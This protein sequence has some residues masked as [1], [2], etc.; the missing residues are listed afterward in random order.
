M[1]KDKLLTLSIVIPVYN[2]ENHLKDCLDA[3]AKQTIKP[4]EVIVVN[5]NSTDNSVKIANSYKF[6][7]VLHEQRQHQVFAQTT[8]FNA[9]KGDILGRIDGDSV[10][11]TNWTERVLSEFN[12]SKLAAV[13]TMAEPYDIPLKRIGMVIFE[14]YQVKLMHFFTSKV[15]LWGSSM[16]MR[17]KFWPYVYEK[18]PISDN[19]WEDHEMS[20]W[21]AELGEV[22]LL[23]DLKIGCS[24]RT[25]H[26]PFFTQLFY[27]FRAIRVFSMHNSKLKT[28]AFFF[29]WY[30]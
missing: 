19:I 6:V 26:K 14:F 18:M 9:A 24:F 22:K 1:L 29:A 30:S 23:K 10:L 15:M 17:A 11:P 16:A 21:L 3:I 28:I 2:E 7:K 13:T 25:V 5:N 12:N 4:L 27:Q 20:Y 8:G